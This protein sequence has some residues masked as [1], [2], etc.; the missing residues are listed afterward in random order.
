MVAFA[1]KP[2]SQRLRK[3]T[4][5]PRVSYDSTL[6]PWSVIQAPFTEIGIYYF[7]LRAAIRPQP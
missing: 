1:S 2:P 3:I 5:A 4:E 7:A 6:P